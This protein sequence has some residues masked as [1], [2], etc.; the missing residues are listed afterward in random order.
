MLSRWMP[1][2]V[3]FDAAWSSTTNRAEFL[4]ALDDSAIAWLSEFNT[5]GELRRKLETLGRK[6]NQHPFSERQIRA[7]IARKD[8][9]R[10]EPR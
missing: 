2:E 8:S 9:L 3:T 4:S 5:A 7:A 6:T 10:K 1:A